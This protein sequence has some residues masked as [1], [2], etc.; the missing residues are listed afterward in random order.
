[1]DY[2]WWVVA[3]AVKTTCENM[4]TGADAGAT[5]VAEC[6]FLC[7]SMRFF[8]VFIFLA[9]L[10][11]WRRLGSA[12]EPRVISDYHLAVQLNCFMTDFWSYSVAIFLK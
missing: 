8:L 5:G 9:T 2:L 6:R 10:K 11:A 12:P 4:C 3:V 1:M 7:A